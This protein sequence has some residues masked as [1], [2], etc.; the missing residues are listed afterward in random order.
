ETPLPTV[1][2]T[3]ERILI[4]HPNALIGTWWRDPPATSANNVEDVYRFHPDGT[5]AVAETV[6]D[7]EAGNIKLVADYWFEDG[8][9][10]TRQPSVGQ[11]YWPVCNRNTSGRWRKTRFEI[12]VQDEQTLKFIV[13]SSSCQNQ[14]QWLIGDYTRITTE[15]VDLHIDPDSGLAINPDPFPDDEPF[16]VE[17][18]L[19][20]VDLTSS[21]VPQLVM[22]L[23]SGETVIIITQPSD[24]ILDTAGTAVDLTAY[25]YE[26]SP[27]NPFRIRA[28]VQTQENGLLISDDLTVLNV[29]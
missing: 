28:T 29:E 12:I 15:P 20:E 8:L 1:S 11:A 19:M 25:E 24:Q 18:T 13:P 6:A 16:I 26:V 22:R 14:M 4:T 3:P 7:V 27:V 9:F 2:P 17:G 5:F 21:D 10:W 23:P